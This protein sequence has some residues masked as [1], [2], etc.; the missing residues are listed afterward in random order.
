MKKLMIAAAIV[1]AAAFAQA[2][3]VGW[4]IGA[5]TEAGAGGKGWGDGYLSGDA[6]IELIIGSTLSDGA[7]TPIYTSGAIDVEFDSG[8]AYPNALEIA[9]MASDTPYYSQLIITQG[10]STLKS[11]IFELQA[12]GVDGDYTAPD[13][14][15]T[16]DG[17]LWGLTDATDGTL[18]GLS[19]FHD[20][21]VAFG[22]AGWQS[23]PEPTSGLLLLL[24]VAGLALRRRRA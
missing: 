5:I 11:G 24:G 8:Y 19:T 13:W 7:I 10:D 15:S 16:Q 18:T 9:A 23:V 4:S 14:T 12:S 3:T 20:T 21:Y 2:A 17:D 22:A 1:C 6:T